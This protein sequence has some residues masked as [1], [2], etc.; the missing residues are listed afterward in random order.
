[1]HTE[2]RVKQSG[3]KAYLVSLLAAMSTLVS[4]QTS[5]ASFPTKPV[6]II[7]PQTPGGASDALARIVGQKLSEKWGQAVVV[8]NRPGAGGNIGMD[9]VAKAPGDGHTLLMSYVGSHA[10]NPSIYSKLPFDPEADFVAVATLANVPF[11]A[12]VNSN[13]PVTNMKSLAAY[14]TQKPVSFGSAGNGSVN[15]LLGE[16]FKS[17]TGAPLV[18]VPMKGSAQAVTEAAAARIDV[19]FSSYISGQG[20]LKDGRFKALAY[21]GPQRSPLLPEVPTLA[22]MGLANLEY[23]QWFGF[24]VP[25]K[26]PEAIVRKLN[27][28]LIKATQHPE[29]MAVIAAQDA[30]ILT[31]SP[32]GLERKIAQESNRYGEVIKRLGGKLN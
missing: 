27:A 21:A 14:A 23:D 11:V 29:L 4:A 28:E 18:H 15:H 17:A 5:P 31:T 16:M 12:A 13:V 8:E 30:T 1:M 25:A 3:W 6:R 19:L 22:E 26:V 20:F 7:V 24:F 9:A 2:Q 32:E 10:I